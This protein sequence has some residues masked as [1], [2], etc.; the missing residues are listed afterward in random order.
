MGSVIYMGGLEN[1]GLLM[2]C[3]SAK[4]TGVITR[5]YKPFNTS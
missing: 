3:N 1:L 5:A 2:S 4:R